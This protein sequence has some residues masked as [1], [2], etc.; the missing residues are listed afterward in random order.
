MSAPVIVSGRVYRPVS[1]NWWT[2]SDHYLES[3]VPHWEGWCSESCDI[4][5]L[6]F[7]DMYAGDTVGWLFIPGQPARYW[8]GREVVDQHQPSLFEVSA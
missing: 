2:S 6:Y 3:V 4:G 1:D 5:L 8:N 7:K